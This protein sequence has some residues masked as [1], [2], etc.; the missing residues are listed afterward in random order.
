MAIHRQDISSLVFHYLGYSSVRNF[1]FRAVRKPVARFVMFHDLP[2][3]ALGCFEAN[4][5]FLKRSTNVVSLDDFISG[6]LSW[7]KTNVV[8]T[9]DDGYKSWVTDAIPTLTKLEL[10]ATFFVSSGFVELSKEGE[11]EF[12]RSKLCVTQP[13][14]KITG[15]LEIEDVRN[16]VKQGFNVGGHTVNHCNLAEVRESGRIREEIQ[17]DKKRLEEIT[18]GKIEY[19]AYPFGDYQNQKLT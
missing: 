4:L 8:I 9:F 10:P 17:E 16:I 15:G 6:R 7:E 12:M 3:E 13:A 18:G 2:M 5:R 19:F 14:R 1:I 11:T